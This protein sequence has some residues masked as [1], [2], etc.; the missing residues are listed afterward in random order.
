MTSLYPGNSKR[1]P[2]IEIYNTCPFYVPYMPT[3]QYILIQ[4][5]LC[6]HSIYNTCPFY[7]KHMPTLFI[8][9]EQW[10]ANIK[11]PP[12]HEPG[13]DGILAESCC[14]KD[15]KHQVYCS[16]SEKIYIHRDLLLGKK[17]RVKINIASLFS[18]Y[19][20]KGSYRLIAPHPFKGVITWY[21]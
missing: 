8:L 19:F 15:R 6:A 9:E 2:W 7:L 21:L 1:S 13:F 17:K 14:M 4:F 11:F 12:C 16:S 18:W 20:G 10:R 5:R 3:L